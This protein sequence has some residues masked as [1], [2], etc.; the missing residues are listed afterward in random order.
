MA[1]VSTPGRTTPERIR[2]QKGRDLSISEPSRH[3]GPSPSA[4]YDHIDP[5][6]DPGVSEESQTTGGGHSVR[7][8]LNE[9]SEIAEFCYKLEGVTLRQLLENDSHC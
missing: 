6:L 8:Q 9:D 1:L 5:L 2:C 7:Y 3:C 4:V